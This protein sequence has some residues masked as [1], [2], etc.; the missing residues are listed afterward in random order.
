MRRAR[1]CIDIE[2]GYQAEIQPEPWQT[3]T[4]VSKNSWGYISHH[5]YKEAAPIIHHLIDIVS[6]NGCLLLNVGPKPDGTIPDEEQALLREIGHWLQVNGEAIYGSRPWRIL[7][8]GPT[9]VVDGQFND[10]DLTFTGRTSA[11]RPETSGCLP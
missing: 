1:P 2:R 9:E 3:C 5:V 10:N 4:S 11:S 6:K 8:E 7:G